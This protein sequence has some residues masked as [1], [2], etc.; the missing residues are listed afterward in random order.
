MGFMQ[1]FFQD[2]S[3]NFYAL[4]LPDNSQH[5]LKKIKTVLNNVM[6]NIT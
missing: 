2:L 3:N 4:V 1:F 5:V 6:K